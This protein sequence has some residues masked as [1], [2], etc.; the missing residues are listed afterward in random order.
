MS[1]LDQHENSND[2]KNYYYKNKNTIYQQPQKLLY[3][4]NVIT[5]KV[6][7]QFLVIKTRDKTITVKSLFGKHLQ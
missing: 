5:I 3:L 1:F 7:Q 4:N 2:S 6:D